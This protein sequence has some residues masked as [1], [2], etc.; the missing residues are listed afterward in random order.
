M[1]NKRKEEMFTTRKTD[2]IS[3]RMITKSQ[4]FMEPKSRC[5]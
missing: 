2:C 5:N 3:H 4:D 1:G